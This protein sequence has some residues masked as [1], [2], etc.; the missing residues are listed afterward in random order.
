VAQNILEP[1]LA[2]L[3]GGISGYKT[4][5]R[6]NSGYR[7]K[8]VV[9]NESATSD[10]CKGRAVD[11]GLLVPDKY[12]KTYQLI[13]QAEKIISYDQLILEYRFPQSV[14]IHA[15]FKPASGRKMAFTMVNDRTYPSKG[16]ALVEPIP[17]KRA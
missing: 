15:S 9:P 1:M 14:W 5:W 10:H 6:I 13:Q 2:I 4:Q 17:P 11:I 3:P 16:Y 7:L 12:N 8:G